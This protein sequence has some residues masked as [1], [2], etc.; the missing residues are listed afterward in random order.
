MSLA[1]AVAPASGSAGESLPPTSPLLLISPGSFPHDAF[2]D[3]HGCMMTILLRSAGAYDTSSE[4][5]YRFLLLGGALLKK[6]ACE[7][8]KSM[9]TPWHT[10]SAHATVQRHVATMCRAAPHALLRYHT[11][12]ACMQLAPICVCSIHH[13]CTPTTAI[14]RGRIEHLLFAT[15]FIALN[16]SE[17][18]SFFILHTFRLR[19]RQQP[20]GL[21]PPVQRMARLVPHIHGPRYTYVVPPSFCLIDY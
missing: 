11:S 5:V 8:H 6:G 16:A 19:S 20:W 13:R 10:R 12:E 21:T 14:S 3:S 4:R 7:Q 17:H 2:A 9:Q 18:L 1:E 15:I